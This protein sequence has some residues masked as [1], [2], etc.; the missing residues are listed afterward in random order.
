MADDHGPMGWLQTGVDIENRWRLI[1][2]LE[3]GEH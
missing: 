3:N 2:S 1:Y